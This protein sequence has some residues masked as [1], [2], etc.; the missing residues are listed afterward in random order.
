MYVHKGFISVDNTYNYKVI[1]RFINDKL[2]FF[3]VYSKIN[4]IVNRNSNSP[5]NYSKH[6]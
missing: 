1:P 6:Q 2:I 4:I 3:K 5:G